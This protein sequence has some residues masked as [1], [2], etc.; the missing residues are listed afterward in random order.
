MPPL[1][2]KRTSQDQIPVPAFGERFS[3]P[4]PHMRSTLDGHL[5]LFDGGRIGTPKSLAD[6]KAGI[7]HYLRQ[8]HAHG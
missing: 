2:T 4:R 1:Q 8:R 3:V 5:A 7:A 6:L